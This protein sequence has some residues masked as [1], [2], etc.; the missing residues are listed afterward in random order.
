MVGPRALIRWKEW[1]YPPASVSLVVGLGFGISAFS[2][3][4]NMAVLFLAAVFV[5]AALFGVRAGIATALLAFPA[6]NF[7]FIEPL[8]TFAVGSLSEL[9]TLCIFLVI[10]TVTGL[11]AGRVQDQAQAAR[12]RVAALQILFDFSRKLGAAATPDAL[13]HAIVLQAHRLTK[14]PAMALLPGPSGLEIRYAWPPESSL[15][16]NAMAAARW[17]MTHGEPAGRGTSTLLTTEWHFRPV[18]T[19]AKTVGVVG[20]RP[21]PR[22]SNLPSE[23]TSTLDSMLDQSAIAIERLSFGAEAARVEAMAATDRLRSALMSSVS[24]DLRTPLTTILGSSSALVQG[25]DRLS[26]EAR[27]ELLLAI[28]EEARR[29][30]Q[31]ISNLL[32]MSRLEAGELKP[33]RD[34]LDPGEVLDSAM[35]RMAPRAGTMAF[36]TQFAPG[37]PLLRADFLLLE[38]VLVNLLDNAIKHA[39]GATR[40]T[41]SL[42]TAADRVEFEVSDD[43]AGIAPDFFH[44]L[45]DRF[46]RVQ[47]GDS[48]PA[49]SG[50]GL[51]ICK[52]FVEAMGGTIAVR[53]PVSEGR[54]A[55][56]VVAF[57]VEEQ[58]D[59]AIS[60][61]PGS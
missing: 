4:P 37:G 21:S 38:T 41:A 1:L 8:Y 50:L 44:H 36:E 9:L 48:K 40:V 30:D 45:F 16:D 46:F 35:A 57:P 34:W 12:S 58:P 42:R 27:N 22:D 26:P 47:R 28:D 18:R 11:L 29:L 52:G 32:N 7:F 60:E 15:D 2:T 51:S 20:L 23:L 24:H 43:G 14:L 10:A 5:G 59:R 25:R 17:C 3:T 53:S 55:A 33:R 6:W 49:G 19:P 39:D 54:G 61:T 13:L 31:Y 56:F